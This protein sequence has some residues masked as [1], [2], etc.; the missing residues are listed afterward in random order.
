MTAGGSGWTGP[1]VPVRGRPDVTCA[2][3]G[4]TR[5]GQ[6][7]LAA[8]AGLLGRPSAVG[9]RPRRRVSCPGH[10]AAA[11]RFGPV[12]APAVATTSGR[13]VMPSGPVLPTGTLF[14]PGPWS[15]RCALAGRPGPARS[16]GSRPEPW[17]SDPSRP[18]RPRRPR[19]GVRL[20]HHCDEGRAL[21][22]LGEGFGVAD[23][24]GANETGGPASGRAA[25]V[26]FPHGG[27][28]FGGQAAV[29]WSRWC[30]RG[31]AGHSWGRRRPDR[32]GPLTAPG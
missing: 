10:E 13:P 5:L 1:V 2:F 26:L 7:A 32:C 12:G 29:P 14:R 6:P 15:S 4:A 16:P 9:P 8:G 23:V 3:G 11:V 30:A 20:G 27:G 25:S 28:L 31:T 21:R 18:P 17:L 22:G 24:R 19:S